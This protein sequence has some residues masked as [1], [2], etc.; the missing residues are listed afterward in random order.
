MP[1]R[2]GAAPRRP[3]GGALAAGAYSRL[4]PASVP[5]RWFGAAIGFHMLAWLALA[6]AVPSWADWHGGLGWPLAA[7]HLVTLGTL[8]A[9]AIGAS[10]QL[11]PVATRQGVRWPQLAGALWWLFVPGMLAVALGMGLARPEWL[12]VGAAAVLVVL[13][14]WGVLLAANLAGARGMPG[15]VL[16]GGAALVGL[17]LRMGSAA[18]LAAR[19]RGRP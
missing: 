18:A 13:L 9:A 17:A 10:V 15:V 3:F 4:L 6:M 19:W 8:V 16:P 14:G 5:M 7:L 11:L 2:P 1:P 12:A